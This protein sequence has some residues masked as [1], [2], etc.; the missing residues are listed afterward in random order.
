[1][2]GRTDN[3]KIA[4]LALWAF[5]HAKQI[6]SSEARTEAGNQYFKVHWFVVIAG[7]R[8]GAIEVQP[9]RTG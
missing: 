3:Q 1:M 9:V 5:Q 8:V 7:R 6:A 4:T 2:H